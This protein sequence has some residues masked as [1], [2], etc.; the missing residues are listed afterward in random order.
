MC[1]PVTWRKKKKKK[2]GWVGVVGGGWGEK[3]EE[4]EGES[5]THNAFDERN[6]H[7]RFLSDFKT[8]HNHKLVSPFFCFCFVLFVF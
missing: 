6:P 3:Q 4:K 8:K 7:S 1:V 2:K 5:Q